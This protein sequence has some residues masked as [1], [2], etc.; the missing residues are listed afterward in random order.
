[1]K[2]SNV[3]RYIAQALVGVSIVLI[4]HFLG[5]LMRANNSNAYIIYDN[6]LEYIGILLGT[7]LLINILIR[8]AAWAKPY[9]ISKYNILSAKR[10]QQQEFDFS[11]DIL[12]EKL[13]ETLNEGGFKVIKT[14]KN[15][16]DIFALA[17]TSLWSWG[18]N[19]YISM[20]EHN[21]KT[22]VNFFSA[23][24]FGAFSWGKNENN[25]EHFLEEFEKS[26]I[27]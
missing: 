24:M 18:E 12:I 11:K 5:S 10:R 23:C 3:N 21:G 13:T 20:K 26:L 25:Y 19:I 4:F 15:S 7:I 16:G 2:K 9:F 14:D 27:I 8:R 6:I 1:M 22:I 17:R